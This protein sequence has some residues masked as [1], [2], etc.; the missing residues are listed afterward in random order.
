MFSRSTVPRDDWG[1]FGL[2][3][4]H[5]DVDCKARAVCCRIS[6]R[7]ECTQAA[8]RAGYS[9]KTANQQGPRLLE[10]ADVQM[11]I[12]AAKEERSDRLKIDAE[13]VLKRLAEEADADIADLYSDDG[14]LQPVKEWP[15][16]WRQGLVQGI[17]VDALYEGLGGSRIQVGQTKKI[18]FSDRVRRI[19]LIGKHVS[20][21]AFE[22]QVSVTGLDALAERLERAVKDRASDAVCSL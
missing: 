3:R 16:I 8:I 20:V 1:Q 7:P 17:E 4:G 13:W 19:E 12:D 9:E 10:N 18:R 6:H 15:L 21:K 5:V 22:V 2:R 14:D 11:A